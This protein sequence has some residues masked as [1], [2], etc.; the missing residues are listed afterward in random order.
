MSNNKYT[1]IE[2][3]NFGLQYGVKNCIV[4]SIMLIVTH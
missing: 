1:C 2:N 4:I 3:Q